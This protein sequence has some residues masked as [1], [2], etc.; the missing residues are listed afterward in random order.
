MKKRYII[1]GIFTGI[2]LQS[3]HYVWLGDHK[4]YHFD[5]MILLII[6]ICGYLLCLKLTSYMADFK[7]IK[8]KS[9]IEI[10]FLTV[11]SIICILP[12]LSISQ[13][14][15]SNI[16]NRTLA[17]YKPLIN[18][19]CRINKN[20]G[21]DFNDWFSD[22]FY[23]R[24]NLI[25]FNNNLQYFLSNNIFITSKYIYDKK[26][27]WTVA[28]NNLYPMQY[29]KNLLK[30]IS[31]NFNLLNQY[32]DNKSI[33][34]YILIVPTKSVIYPKETACGIYNKQITERIK[35]EQNVINYL[36]KNTD[37]N[38]IYPYSELLEGKKVDYVF[39]KSEHHWT[40]WGAYIGYKKL[41]KEI[42][43]DFP[44][45]NV[46]SL[47]E[48]NKSTNK[49]V[50]A[51][52]HREFGIG[53]TINRMAISKHIKKKA[54][55]VLYNY[56]DNKNNKTLRC[57]INFDSMVKSY[58]YK[59]TNHLKI[60]SA[61]TSMNENLNRYLPYGAEDMLYMRWN[62]VKG[63]KNSDTFKF[64]KRFDKKIAAYKPNIMVVCLTFDN[65][66]NVPHLFDKE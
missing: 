23:L 42:K 27:N 40:D 48:Y 5:L 59:N 9:R 25:I 54:H 7:N 6:I 17:V 15:K 49:L 39:F 35:E 32:C 61:G 24:N 51:D 12:L 44:D 64:Y 50:C 30:Q 38:I 26:T 58:H 46:I 55:K 53:Q 4:D 37:C 43:N 60:F 63:V 19:D 21:K 56:Y 45:F 18:K 29:N 20:F 8:E 3:S 1:A 66:K 33:K 10:I 41:A 57:N 13:E 22:R 16:E 2:I 34:L 31:D 14:N 28:K 36:K 65:L 52:F 62:N 11:F 47:T